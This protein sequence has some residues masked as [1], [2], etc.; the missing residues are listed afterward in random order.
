M[1][2]TKPTVSPL[3]RLLCAA[4]IESVVA[5]DPESKPDSTFLPASDPVQPSE[6]AGD[7]NAFYALRV[8]SVSKDTGA[9]SVVNHFPAADQTD[10]VYGFMGVDNKVNTGFDLSKLNK[11]DIIYLDKD[12]NILG[13][14]AHVKPEATTTA[15]A[16]KAPRGSGSMGG[17][18]LARFLAN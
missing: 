16:A 5:S 13:V 9:V 11:G 12:W 3:S 1:S 6:S 8:A 14:R 17:D 15:K 7:M 2:N 10:T 4:F 18:R